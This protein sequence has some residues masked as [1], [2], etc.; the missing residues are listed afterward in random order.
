MYEDGER[1]YLRAIALEPKR[2]DFHNGLAILYTD[3]GDLEK[4]I[5]SYRKAIELKPNH[6]YYLSL[7]EAYEKRGKFEEATKAYEES[8]KIKP[9]FTYALYNFSLIHLKQGRPQEAIE[10]LRKTIEIEPTN[11]FAN[12]AL[13]I[14]YVRTGNKTGAM[15]QY[16]ILQN[17]NPRAAADLLDAIPQ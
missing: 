7:A 8:I 17:L 3:K 9:T 10:L 11:G 5:E 4:A 2:A 16:Y 12:H 1:E 15:Q 13:G 6:V 14:A